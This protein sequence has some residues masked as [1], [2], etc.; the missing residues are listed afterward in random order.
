ML[1]TTMN[2]GRLLPFL[3]WIT[4][5]AG[6]AEPSRAADWTERDSAGVTLVSNHWD[7]S[8][9]GCATIVAEPILTIPSG[10]A[11]PPLF[12]VRGGAVLDDG[13]IA[14]LNA[15]SRQTLFFGADGQLERVVGR[16]GRGPGEFMNPTWLGRGGGDT[17]VVWD[18]GL[19]RLTLLGGTG[20][21]LALHQVHVADV[22]GK[23]IAISGRFDDGS[24]FYSPGPL[25]FFDGTP[26]VLR[27]PEVYGRYD[28]AA[29][30]VEPLIT[31]AG[32]ET[33]QEPGPIYVLPFGK[34]D[35]AIAHGDVLVIGDNGTSALRS[36]DLHGRL[37]RVVEWVSTPV[38]VTARD[39][40][41]Y[42]AHHNR[43]FPRHAR[44]SADASRFAADR[45]RFSQLRRDRAGWLWVGTYRPAW[46]S[47]GGWLVFD[48]RGV[49]RCTVDPP[50]PSFGMLEIGES[51]VLAVRRNRDGEETVVLH[52]LARNTTGD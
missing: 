46:E 42:W 41:E 30:R 4:A 22:G 3:A 8:A 7:G 19:M 17:L 18:G 44:R 16:Q 15:G 23:P 14:I 5:C 47:R 45:P 12:R 50:G 51:H 10:P 28:T 32:V 33:V 38:A 36:Y 37:R 20:E 39:R 27:L 1:R 9:R 31:A 43:I 40:R 29:R 6:D 25:V 24:F 21:L 48:E 2:A 13:R 34:E 35:I 52:R 26:G 11:D 49:L